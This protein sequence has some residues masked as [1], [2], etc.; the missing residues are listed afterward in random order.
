M[1]I[2]DSVVRS[3]AVY[4]NAGGKFYDQMTDIYNRG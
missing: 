2:A 3:N 1:A 4:K